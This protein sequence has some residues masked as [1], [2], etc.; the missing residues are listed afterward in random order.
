MRAI[1]IIAISLALAGCSAIEP[2]YLQHPSTGKTVYCRGWW[3][4]HARTHLASQLACV[5]DF[6]QQGYERIPG[7]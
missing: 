1:V 7:P 5:E 6:K 2:I 3:G 4:P